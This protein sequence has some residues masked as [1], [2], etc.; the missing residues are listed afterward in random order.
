MKRLNALILEPLNEEVTPKKLRQF[1]AMIMKLILTYS[2]IY[3][4][5][6]TSYRFVT[7]LCEYNIHFSVQFL[8][9]KLVA[10]ESSRPPPDRGGIFGRIF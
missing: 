4:F 9:L 1:T 5:L 10:P 7:F 3:C 6:R 8:T 2:S